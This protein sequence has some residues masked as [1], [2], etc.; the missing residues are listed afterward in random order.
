LAKLTPASSSPSADTASTTV[1]AV[2]ETDLTSPG[3]TV[4]TVAY[5]SPE[6]ALGKPLDLRNDLFSFGAVLYEMATGPLPFKGD[7]SAA[8]ST[9][10]FTKT[11]QRRCDSTMTFPTSWFVSSHK[12]DQ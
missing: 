12:T 9:A 5:M 4:G 6:Q 8:I 1:G 11:L 3:S 10:F 2:R 7:T